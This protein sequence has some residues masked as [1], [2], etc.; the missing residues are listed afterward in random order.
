MACRRRRCTARGAAS[1][2][3]CRRDG[4]WGPG[5]REALYQGGESYY[6]QPRSV[7]HPSSND[8]NSRSHYNS[9]IGTSVNNAC[10][11]MRPLWG[12][13]QEY[14]VMLHAGYAVLFEEQVL[15]FLHVV[16]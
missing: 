13:L 5:C 4:E 1:S 14:W 11:H 15:G 16:V 12:R 6:R 7:C 8:Y 3:R 10:S 9:C 2:L